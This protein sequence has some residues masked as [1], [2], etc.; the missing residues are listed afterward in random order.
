M[1]E[2]F[3]YSESLARHVLVPVYDLLK[4]DIVTCVARKGVGVHQTTEG[5][6]ALVQVS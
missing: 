3:G 1:Y 6:S 4:S 2:C 5:I